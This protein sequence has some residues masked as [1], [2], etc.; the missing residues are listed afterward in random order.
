MEDDIADDDEAA[1]FPVPSPVLERR[2]AETRL[3]REQADE[4]RRRVSAQD[5]EA[6]DRRA[7]LERERLEALNAIALRDLDAFKAR[8]DERFATTFFPFVYSFS[9]A[10]ESL[11]SDDRVHRSFTRELDATQARRRPVLEVDRSVIIERVFESGGVTVL[12]AAVLAG[13][14]KIIHFLRAK[15]PQLL[16]MRDA[17]FGWT[18][19]ALACALYLPSSLRA[20]ADPLQV[21]YLRT[22][23]P[24]ADLEVRCNGWRHDAELG[25]T[26]PLLDAN[27]SLLG[28]LLMHDER[29]RNVF[30]EYRNL[31]NDDGS[32]NE[33]EKAKFVAESPF[34]IGAFLV[35]RLN[36]PALLGGAFGSRHFWELLIRRGLILLVEEAIKRP[37]SASLLSLRDNATAFYQPAP[38]ALA[39]SPLDWAQLV[40]AQPA[41][42]CTPSAS[43]QIF[44]AMLEEISAAVEATPMEE[45]TTSWAPSEA[46]T[47]C[48]HLSPLCSELRRDPTH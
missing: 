10:A 22:F 42:R 26:T 35:R 40:Y 15:L 44:R 9:K 3:R 46:C 36:K 4:Q 24:S 14:V 5:Q 33:S 18:P 37:D 45:S 30:Y 48:R 12:H 41:F 20:L 17:T 27:L 31:V 2:R 13:A 6:A 34:H 16:E 25:R 38:P 19:A 7:R 43:P 8:F 11:R 21:P 29:Y 1:E 32:V 47:Q 28:L 23:Y 39:R